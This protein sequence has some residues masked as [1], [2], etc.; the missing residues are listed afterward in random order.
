[1]KVIIDEFINYLEKR[2]AAKNTIASYERD[3]V[4][5]DEYFTNKGKKIFDLTSVDM[6]EYLDN[7]TSLGKSNAT[8]SRCSASIKAFYKY[9]VNKKLAEKNIV[10]DVATYKVDKKCPSILTRAEIKE[11]LEQPITKDL[12]GERDKIMLEVL[13]STG[14]RVTE[15]INLEVSDINFNNSTLKVMQGKTFRIIKLNNS[16]LKCLTNYV[17]N[18]RQLLIRNEEDDTLFLNASGKKLTRQGFWKIL[19]QYKSAA[20]ITKD[21]TPHTIRHSFAVHQLKDGMDMK[22]LQEVLGHTDVAT[23]MMYNNYL[24]IEV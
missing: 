2:H 15:L 10:K 18:I 6:Q 11:L 14:I 7:L 12:K 9:L 1:M 24:D 16:T 20:N 23:T 21:L 8:I 4:K 19:K 17:L 3:I 5:F 22:K 13:Y